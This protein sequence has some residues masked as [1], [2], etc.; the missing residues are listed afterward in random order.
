MNISAET[1]AILQRLGVDPSNFTAGDLAVRSPLTGE[2][3]ARVALHSA[4]QVTASVARAHQAFL[5]WRTVP[6]P[7][8]GELVR[9]FGEELRGARADLGRLVCIEAGK[10]PSEGLGEVQEMIEIGRAHV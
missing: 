7:V 6:A 3:I 5:G 4:E 9:L 1:H 2:E 8:R 10:I